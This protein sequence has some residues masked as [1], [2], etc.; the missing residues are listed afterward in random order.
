MQNIE[1]HDLIKRHPGQNF[2]MDNAK[3][4]VIGG[5]N[6]ALDCARSAVRLGAEKVICTCLES[7]NDVPC[8]EWEKMEAFEEGVE[9]IEGWAPQ[10]FTGVHNELAGVSYAKVKDFKK[11][12]GRITFTTDVE[13]TMDLDADYVIVAIGQTSHEMWQEYYENENVFFAGDVK[14][15]ANS[16][17]NA[18]A[19]GKKTAIAVDERLTGREIKDVMEN[20]EI[21]LAPQLEKV[22]PATRLRVMRPEMPIVPAEIRIKNFDE[23]ET[24]YSEEVISMETNRCLQC[25]YQSI[26]SLKC[27]GCG[28]CMRACP[29][30]DA[31]TMVAMEEGGAE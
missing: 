30:G 28:A 29:K 26:D 31:I 21:S 3:V 17:V 23:V 4:V 12:N 25:G 24:A 14:E 5:G 6:V 27:I 20:H 10:E 18:M 7:G 9:L 22:L 15:P 2:K 19:S 11:E 1:N 16:V 8:H 13:N